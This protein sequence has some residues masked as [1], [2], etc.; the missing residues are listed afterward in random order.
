MPAFYDEMEPFY[1]AFELASKSAKAFETISPNL[2]EGSNKPRA[3][4]FTY[5]VVPTTGRKYIPGFV[6]QV[7]SDVV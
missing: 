4:C 2:T 7:S 5:Q 1:I 6:T 3:G